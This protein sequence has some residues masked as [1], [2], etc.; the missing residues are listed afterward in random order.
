MHEIFNN[1][2]LMDKYEEPTI[3]S[4]NFQAIINISNVTPNTHEDID[5]YR[6]ND[7]YNSDKKLKNGG[8]N[9]CSEFLHEKW[10]AGKKIGVHCNNG[11]QRSIP[12]LVYYLLNYHNI[13]LE[14]TVTL[15]LQE[16]CIEYINNVKNILK[17]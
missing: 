15:A 11:Y 17:M 6:I 13:P 16:N 4:K 10:C 12:F 14:E 5:Y 3:D 7:I 1:I 9:N 8:Y 2:W